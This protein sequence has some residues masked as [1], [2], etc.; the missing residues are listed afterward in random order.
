MNGKRKQL[1]IGTHSGTFHCDEALGCWLLQQTNKYKDADIIRSRDPEVLKEA[2]VVLDVGGIYSPD[3]QRFD[4]HQAGFNENFGHGFKTKLSSAGLVYKHYGREVLKNIL[5]IPE[6]DKNVEIMYLTMYQRFI[7]A[8]DAIDNGINQ[9]EGGVGPLYQDSTNLASRV[10]KL[11]PNW[12]EDSS[13]EN[14]YERFLKAVKLTGSEFQEHA[15]N[16][17]NVW[18]PAR[19][20]VEEFI[21]NRKQIDESGAIFRLDKFV[22]WKEH[23]FELEK[24]M[25]IEG[26]LKYCLYED[27][28]E[29]KWRIQAVAVA[30]GSFDSRLAL[31]ESWRGKR[32]EELSE[33]LNLEGCTFV[34]AS[35]FIGGHNNYEGVLEMAR[36]ALTFQKPS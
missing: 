20:Y 10:S 30:S 8:V 32:D 33:T 23:L 22:P 3:E 26:E 2:D 35:G 25:G 17:Y 27:D 15:E 4:H 29:H 28:R 16:Y 31:P 7:E 12:M 11:N 36:R 21:N 19:N 6:D 34:H 5:K 13:P 1:T 9:W 14:L 24:E 18:L